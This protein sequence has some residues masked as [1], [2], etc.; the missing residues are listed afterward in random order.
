MDRRLRFTR[1]PR[2]LRTQL[3]HPLR[4]EA[5]EENHRRRYH[6]TGTGSYL[7]LLPDAFASLKRA[8]IDCSVQSGV[9]DGNRQTT[10]RPL[11]FNIDLLVEAA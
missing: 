8:A 7:P 6:I 11:T 5:V 10:E 2:L 1:R 3:E 9:P 4:C